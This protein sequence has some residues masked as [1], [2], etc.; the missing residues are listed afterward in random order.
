MISITDISSTE[1]A[2]GTSLELWDNYNQQ[3]IAISHLKTGPV[4]ALLIRTTELL[5]QVGGLCVP[6]EPGQA[7]H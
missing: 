3:L 6:C 5:L 1:A 4:S 2:A 7:C